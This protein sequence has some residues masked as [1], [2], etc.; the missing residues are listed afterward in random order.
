MESDRNAIRAM[1]VRGMIEKEGNQ[2]NDLKVG[3][4]DELDGIILDSDY[5]LHI[6]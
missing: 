4:N 2:N 5:Q 3:I 6:L 1:L